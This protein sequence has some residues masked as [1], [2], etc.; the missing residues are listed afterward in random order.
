MPKGDQ[1]QKRLADMIGVAVMVGG[2]AAGEIE[3]AKPK[4][5]S[6]AAL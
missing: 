1:D 4:P 5:K 3:E 2:I 6:A